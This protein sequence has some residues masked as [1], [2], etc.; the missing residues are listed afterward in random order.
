MATSEVNN[1][2]KILEDMHK[3][4]VV[5]NVDFM[6]ISALL[7]VVGRLDQVIELLESSDKI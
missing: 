2:A 6:K 3:E 5:S 4:G 1:S 7:A